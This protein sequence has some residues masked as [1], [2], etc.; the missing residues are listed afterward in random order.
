M[1]ARV[2]PIISFLLPVRARSALAAGSI[3]LPSAGFRHGIRTRVF[4]PGSMALLGCAGLLLA[5]CQAPSASLESAGQV[6]LTARSPQKVANHGGG[7]VMKPAAQASRYEV[8][9]GATGSLPDDGSEPPEGVS[10][11]ENGKFT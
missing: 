7:A 9:S 5:S 8:F 6:D 4:G 1:D 2:S 10:E 3:A 11:G